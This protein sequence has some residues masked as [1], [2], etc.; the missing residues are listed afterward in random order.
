M[1]HFTERQQNSISSKIQNEQTK[2]F[3]HANVEE[4]RLTCCHL[5]VSQTIP[6]LIFQALHSRR[7]NM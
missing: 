5:H 4:L 7:L 6:L 1:C 2:E 3:L